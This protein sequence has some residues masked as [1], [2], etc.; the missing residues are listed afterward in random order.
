M[1]LL[2][3]NSTADRCFTSSWHFSLS[4]LFPFIFFS[5][6]AKTDSLIPKKEWYLVE[7]EKINLFRQTTRKFSPKKHCILKSVLRN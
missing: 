6:F 1:P 7:A 5:F 2:L 3:A 4:L